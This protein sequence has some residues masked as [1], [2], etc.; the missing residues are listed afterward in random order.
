M[1][2]KN[3]IQ[4]AMPGDGST[5]EVQETF[6]TIQGEG[7]FAGK[8]ALFIRLWGCNLRCYFCDTDFESNRQTLTL[9]D[10]T[11]RVDEIQRAHGIWP[12]LVVMTGGE[13]LL[14][15]VA[16][17]IDHLASEYGIVTQIETA[18]TT[19]PQDSGQLVASLREGNA[20][21]VCSPKTGKV[22]PNVTEWCHHWK[23]LV[24]SGQQGPD[25]LPNMS[26]QHE[27]VPLDMY[28]PPLEHRHLDTIWLQPCEEYD[29]FLLVGSP[30][31]AGLNLPDFAVTRRFR[32]ELKSQAN[33]REAAHLC[34]KHGYRLSLQLH[35][36]VGLP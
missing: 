33:L 8:P 36:I 20:V 31:E 35:K 18:G 13:P 25:G 6:Y 23:Y 28:R 24:R 12:N 21:L 34:M 17:V 14:Q 29:R 32:Q 26:T 7:P 11:Q 16:K 19:W 22:H 1:F 9:S 4:K 5:L 3:Q 30:R 2:G 15:N 10:I 27:D